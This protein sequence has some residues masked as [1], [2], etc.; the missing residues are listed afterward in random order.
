MYVANVR[1]S[2]PFLG[3]DYNKKVPISRYFE[4]DAGIKRNPV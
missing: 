2:G 3:R 1:T 4:I